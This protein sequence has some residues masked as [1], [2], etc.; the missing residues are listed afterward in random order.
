M[1]I[2]KTGE[3]VLPFNNEGYL[4]LQPGEYVELFCSSKFKSPFTTSTLLEAT[5]SIYNLFEIGGKVYRFD[6]LSCQGQVFHTA[7]RTNKQCFGNAT[8]I[9]VGFEVEH[10]FALTYEVCHDE[11]RQSTLWSHYVQTPANMGFQKSFPRSSFITGNFYNKK[12]ID[13]V[14]TK[15]SYKAQ[16]GKILG[17][18]RVD[19]L[20]E[21]RRNLY[22][23]RGHLAAKTDF[24]YGSQ[25]RATFYFINA[26]PQWQ[27]F[28]GGNWERVESSVKQF[29]SSRNI[30]IEIYTGTYGVLKLKDVNGIERELFLHEDENNNSLL[31][32]PLFYYK[33]LI[34][35]ESQKGIVLIG[36]N[37][38][39][40]TIEQIEAEYILCDDVSDLITWINWERTNPI[41]GYS[42]ACDVNEW[43]QVVGHLPC[44]V[45]TSGLL[46]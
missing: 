13:R 9:E 31:P 18:S 25:Q 38:P 10:R 16:F 3:F 44:S 46:Y 2:P 15:V 12:N 19:E 45:K 23:A 34:D 22:L 24:I 5:C 21:D 27:S 28:N 8:H 41:R 42:Y 20:F 37:N 6:Q 40:A 14:Y 11:I 35:L 30:E 17:E 26:A 32:V 43:T 36:L 4:W 39:H 1:L 7:R 29:V 33:V